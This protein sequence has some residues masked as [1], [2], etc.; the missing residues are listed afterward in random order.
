MAKNVFAEFTP[1]IQFAHFVYPFSHLWGGLC[2]FIANW[3]CFRDWQNHFCDCFLCALF[4]PWQNWWHSGWGRKGEWAPP[5][6]NLWANKGHWPLCCSFYI[7]ILVVVLFAIIWHN[8]NGGRAS[9]CRNRWCQ[10]WIIDDGRWG[11]RLWLN[12]FKFNI[13]LI[14]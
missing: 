6:D 9:Q 11:R 13:N 12:I 14:N 10:L 4:W 7:Q 2:I 5:L 1:P 8:L 3:G